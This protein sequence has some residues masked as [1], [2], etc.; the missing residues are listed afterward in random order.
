MRKTFPRILLALLILF[1]GIQFVRPEQ[2]NPASDPKLS[3]ASA[4]AV[5][6]DERVLGIIN[7]SCFDCHSNQTRWP[8]Y[9]KVAPLSW[10]VAHDVEEGRGKMNFSLWG[11]YSTEDKLHALKD[12]CEEVTEG[13]MPP[14]NYLIA[15]GDAD[16]SDAE[17]DLLCAWAN[18]ERVRLGASPTGE[19]GGK[20]DAGKEEDD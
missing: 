15:H 18:Q 14:G 6:P 3:I 10:T 12:L 16:L 9:S 5:A 20:R 13:K 4:A 8:W 1:I 2:T 11:S 19:T 17:R 7:R